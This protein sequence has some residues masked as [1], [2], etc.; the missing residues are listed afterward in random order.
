MKNGGETRGKCKSVGKETL[1][2]GVD[3]HTHTHTH[4]SPRGGKIETN[5]TV[6]RSIFLSSGLSGS[7]DSENLTETGLSGVGGVGRSRSKGVKRVGIGDAATGVLINVADRT[8]SPRV[9][10]P[11]LRESK[12]KTHQ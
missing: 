7:Q 10:E 1:C 6:R 5:T 2:P 8:N 11:D 4:A 9:D 3:T 12:Y